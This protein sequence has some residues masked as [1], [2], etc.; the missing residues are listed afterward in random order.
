MDNY[1]D[2]QIREWILALTAQSRYRECSATVR[3]FL[4]NR[5]VDPMQCLWLATDLGDGPK[6]LIV[7]SDLTTVHF[8]VR[9]N[10]FDRMHYDFG[11]WA[12]V[13]YFKRANE[14]ARTILRSGDVAAFAA[15]ASELY[16]REWRDRDRHTPDAGSP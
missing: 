8:N 4:W 1:T 16:K 7:L 3:L 2:D 6:G 11:P 12:P 13:E 15:S 9:D 10:R 14:V 5:D